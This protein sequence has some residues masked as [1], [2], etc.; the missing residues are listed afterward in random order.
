MLL[1]HAQSIITVGQ[2]RS[3]RLWI[4]FCIPFSHRWV[5]S[6]PENDNASLALDT[7]LSGGRESLRALLRGSHIDIFAPA[8]GYLGTAKG[9]NHNR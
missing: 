1:L 7:E 3:E 4:H 8:E 9:F 5:T 2:F 6:R